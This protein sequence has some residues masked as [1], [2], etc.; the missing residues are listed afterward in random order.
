[1]SITSARRLA[2]WSLTSVLV[3]ATAATAQTDNRLEQIKQLNRVAAQ[4]VESEI[5]EAIKQAVPLIKTEPAGALAIL[6]DALETANEDTALSDTQRESLKRLLNAHIRDAKGAGRKTEAKEIDTVRRKETAP[7]ARDDETKARVRDIGDRI[8]RTRDNLAESRGVRIKQGAGLSAADRDVANSAT[9]SAKDMEFPKNWKEL[10]AKRT[11]GV[12]MTKPEKAIMKALDSTIEANF[13]NIRFEDVIKYLEDK[14]GVTILLDKLALEQQAVTYETT[15]K[16]RA[17]KISMRT[18][19][20]RIL[21]DHG[22]T[23][24]IKDEAIQVTTPDRAREMT[25]VRT[26]YIGDI[27]SRINFDLGPVLNEQQVLENARRIIDMIQTQVEPDS[28]QANKGN[29]T[30]YF[31]PS[32]MVLVVKATAEVHYMLGGGMK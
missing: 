19:L 9:P 4:K 6:E 15:V 22:L 30:I 20:R 24:Y 11:K 28:W 16:Y 21:A 8:N 14:T 27:V 3:L 29:G 5:R 31:E 13:D 18:V 1:M 12:E 17:R 10:V 32:R 2:F 7:S 23:Y 26:Y 25:S